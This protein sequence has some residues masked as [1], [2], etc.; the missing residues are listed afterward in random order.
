MTQKSVN[1]NKITGNSR[2]MI[3]KGAIIGGVIGTLCGLLLSSSV[4]RILG[5]YNAN[6][7][8]GA[9]VGAL[10]GILIGVLISFWIK[11]YSL[12]NKVLK[13]NSYLNEA[14]IE[15]REEELELYKN[16]VKTGEVKIHKEILKEEKN[17]TVPIIREELVIENREIGEESKN[18]ASADIKTIRIPI[19]EEHIEVSKYPVMLED[20]SIFKQPIQEIQH[21][22]ETLKREKLHVKT[23]G[24]V[25]VLE[26]KIKK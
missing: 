20:V 21:I 12:K 1:A 5:I 16:R 22:E 13:K 19:R 26:K 17:I 4:L 14:K 2:D 8:Y 6:S 11:L 18:N 24:K 9:I 15:L 10:F 7:T 25:N 3:Y 23:K